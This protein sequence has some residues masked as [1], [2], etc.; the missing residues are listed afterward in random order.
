MTSH[1]FTSHP[2]PTAS[3]GTLGVNDVQRRTHARA[4]FY[5]HGAPAGGF[6]LFCFRSL[7]GVGG[8]TCGQPSQVNAAAP[9]WLQTLSN[10]CDELLFSWVSE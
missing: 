2:C 1:P 3:V 5:T 10:Y 4:L 7:R 9:V 6:M 8:A